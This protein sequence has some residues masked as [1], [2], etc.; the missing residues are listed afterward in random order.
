V[1]GA[2]FSVV[3]EGYFHAMGIPLMAGREF[4]SR[5]RSGAP[6]VAVINRAA[7]H[8]LYPDENPIGKHL[9]VQWTGPPQAEIV[10]VAADSRFDAMEAAPEPFIFLPNSQ[11]PSLFAGLVVRTAGDPLTMIAA[12]R[13]AIR[14]VDPEQGVME[15][16]TMERRITD[17]VARPRLQT[18]LLGAFGVLALVLACIGIYGVLAYAVSQRLPEI[19]VRLALGA[20]PGRILGEVLRGGLG[21]T[22]VGLFIGVAVALALTRYLQAL[23]YAV[24]STDPAVF[25]LAIATLLLVAA[26]ACYIP[27]RRAAHVDPMA[28]LREE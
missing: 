4:D 12:V 22:A 5:D 23:L 6:L 20:T 27:A 25:A 19:G 9:M 24:R 17:S 10:G 1:P 18:I 14:S 3:S 2:G 21:L 26:A 11:R 8:M 28:V 15:T 7:A 16:A 13:E